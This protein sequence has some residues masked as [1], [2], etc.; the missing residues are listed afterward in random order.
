MDPIYEA[1]VSEVTEEHL[2]NLI[3]D[4]IKSL[5]N[6]LKRPNIK[7][8]KAIGKNFNHVIS[9]SKLNEAKIDYEEAF[10]GEIDDDEFSPYYLAELA[11]DSISG[12]KAWIKKNKENLED[13]SSSSLNNKLEK[14]F[15]DFDAFAKKNGVKVKRFDYEPDVWN[16]FGEILGI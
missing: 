11:L 13:F 9:N 14:F 5:Q 15:K 3:A 7:T 8:L 12:L 2:K 1:Y 4:T 16:A 10:D 6:Q